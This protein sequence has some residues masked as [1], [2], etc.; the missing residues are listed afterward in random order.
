MIAQI[1]R[2]LFSLLNLIILVDI[3]IS[4]FLSPYHPFREFLDRIVNPLLSP[5][6]KLMP[7]TGMIDFSPIVLIILLQVLEY[8][9]LIPFK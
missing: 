3:I 4:Y 2:L 7:R 9:L 6:R 8:I 1:I 5:I